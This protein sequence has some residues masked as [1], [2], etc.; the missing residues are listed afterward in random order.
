MQQLCQQLNKQLLHNI[1]YDFS[2]MPYHNVIKLH[3]YWILG[4]GTKFNIDLA[5]EKHTIIFFCIA[6]LLDCGIVWFNPRALSGWK[7]QSIDLDGARHF[8][9]MRL[10]WSNYLLLMW[11]MMQVFQFFISKMCNK[12][13]TCMIHAIYTNVGLLIS[14]ENY[15]RYCL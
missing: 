2:M 15:H 4:V 9:D 3:K 1:T 10:R 7:T 6:L 11:F 8:R 12:G 13:V 5:T 14:W